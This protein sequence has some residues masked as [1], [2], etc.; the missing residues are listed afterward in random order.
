MNT[1]YEF[2]DLDDYLNDRMSAS[3]KAAFEQTLTNDPALQ[4][5]LDAL[6]AENTVLQLLRREHLLQQLEQWSDES[7][8]EKKTDPVQVGRKTISSRNLIII[9]LIALLLAIGIAI[10]IKNSGVEDTPSI[11]QPS[12]PPAQLVDTLKK[13]PVQEPIAQKT[14]KENLP[15][16]DN[17]AYAALAAN[18]YVEEDFSQTLMG[19]GGDDAESRYA[20]A[21]DFYGKKQYK[22]AL[23]L[24]KNP[25][26]QLE[27]EYLYL[28]GYTY[29]HLGQY[30][31]AEQDFKAFRNFTNSDR[32]LD[33]V[34]CEV[35][36]LTRQLPASRSRLDKVLAEISANPKHPYFDRAQQLKNKLK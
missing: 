10:M 25:D 32:K 15:K 3:D 1:P 14:P 24:L 13:T 29:Y 36:C 33:A 5:R 28:R 27:Q 7:V 23:D 8:P 18:A 26:K 16:V 31:K 22:K 6:R 30:A 21:V 12:T 2:E 9:A 19:G 11:N 17:A 4:Q 20:Q 34:W 35:F